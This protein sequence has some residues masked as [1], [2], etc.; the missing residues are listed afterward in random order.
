MKKV[1]YTFGGQ[2]GE[3]K[4]SVPKN[5]IWSPELDG[6]MDGLK[7][8]EIKSQHVGHKSVLI[9]TTQMKN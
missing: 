8:G 6:W 5:G 9:C 2:K 4:P 7:V 3:S 1:Y